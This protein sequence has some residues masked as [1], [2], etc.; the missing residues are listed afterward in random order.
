[1]T[2][3][4]ANVM[5]LAQ[6]WP[7]V[8]P[9]F[10]NGRRRSA[11]WF[12]CVFRNCHGA[13]WCWCIQRSCKDQGICTLSAK[14]GVPRSVILFGKR[15]KML[16]RGSKKGHKMGH[17]WMVLD[18]HRWWIAHH[19]RQWLINGGTPKPGRFHKMF[20]SQHCLFGTTDDQ[21]S[22]QGFCCFYFIIFSN[23]GAILLCT[24]PNCFR[25]SLHVCLGGFTA[26]G[27][28]LVEA[29]P[30]PT[31][32]LLAVMEGILMNA[33]RTAPMS[34]GGSQYWRRGCG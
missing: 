11:L 6:R 10:E 26:E 22:E 9:S 25:R 28:F 24:L 2:E 8:D 18:Q 33:G 19:N 20:G 14:R 16:A 12:L 32:R 29:L 23:R 1:M 7:S 30:G 15:R 31:Q 21:A 3:G 5:M 4:W 27:L 17:S 34:I 13:Q